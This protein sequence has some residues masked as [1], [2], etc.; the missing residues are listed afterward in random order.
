M[1]VQHTPLIQQWV[2][3]L[4]LDAVSD[5]KV[6]ERQHIVP[7]VVIWTRYDYP[8]KCARDYLLVNLLTKNDNWKGL[9]IQ[10]KGS[11]V[12]LDSTWFAGVEEL[13]DNNDNDDVSVQSEDDNN[14]DSDSDDE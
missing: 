11:K 9:I 1:F 3:F 8:S 10:T 13:P 4:I 14:V 2:D 7:W 12:L 5:K 6:M